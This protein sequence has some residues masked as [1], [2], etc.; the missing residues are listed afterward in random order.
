MIYRFRLDITPDQY[1]A[2]Y[3]GWVKNVVAKDTH[4]LKIQFPALSLQ[5]FVVADGVH[6]WFELHASDQGKFIGLYKVS[7]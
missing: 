1:L 6:G 5:K 2:Y 4:G 7:D 3:R